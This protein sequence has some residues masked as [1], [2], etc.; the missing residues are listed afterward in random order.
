MAEAFEQVAPSVWRGSV[1]HM[2]YAVR[3]GRADM[4]FALWTETPI[5]RHVSTHQSFDAAVAAAE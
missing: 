1:R 5:A 2:I 3:V 4:G